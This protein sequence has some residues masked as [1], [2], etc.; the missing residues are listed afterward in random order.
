M[1]KCHIHSTIEVMCGGENAV[2]QIQRSINNIIGTFIKTYLL[3]LSLMA[4][5]WF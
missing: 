5:K 4:P 1:N 3:G 2:F